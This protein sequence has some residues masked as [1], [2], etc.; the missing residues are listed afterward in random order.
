MSRFNMYRNHKDLTF[1][2][3]II[4]KPNLSY[5]SRSF[6]HFP[7]NFNILFLIKSFFTMK[8]HFEIF[9]VDLWYSFQV[10]IWYQIEYPI[11]I[12]Q[13]GK[14]LLYFYLA[15]TLNCFF[16]TWI[17]EIFIHFLLVNSVFSNYSAS[18]TT[19][20]RHDSIQFHRN[21]IERKCDNYITLNGTWFFF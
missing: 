18:N 16:L 3:D 8:R 4:P 14:H 10:H 20:K 19:G 15:R 7:R 9:C 1:W 21:K 17:N 13:R 11:K 2:A 12:L 5:L 6:I